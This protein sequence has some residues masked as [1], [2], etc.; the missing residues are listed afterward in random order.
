[1]TTETT[2]IGTYQVNGQPNV[3]LVEATVN[4]KHSDI[5]IGKFT[6]EQDGVDRPDWQSPWDE[7][8]LNEDGTA[9]IGNWMDSPKGENEK[10]RLAFFL[11]YVDFQKPLITPFHQIAFGQPEKM[12]ERLS[13]MIEY[14]QP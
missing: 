1:M 13:S 12:P 4:T 8:Y 10:T 3:H 14:E 6:Q 11:H 5:D 9:I 7:K 2:L